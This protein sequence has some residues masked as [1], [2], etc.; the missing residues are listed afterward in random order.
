MSDEPKTDKPDGK[1]SEPVE[2]K[3]TPQ[4]AVA[5]A[6][7]FA[8]ANGVD[9]FECGGWVHVKDADYFRELGH[10][11]GDGTYKILL[12]K[13]GFDDGNRHYQTGEP[14]RDVAMNVQVNDQ[15]GE[16][17]VFWTL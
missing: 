13:E 14:L 1:Q 2:R 10:S 12:V 11:P 4:E 5:L 3:I 17:A 8:R 15:T 7:D 9:V 16:A 6:I